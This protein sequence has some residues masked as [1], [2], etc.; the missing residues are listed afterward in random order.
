[1]SVEKLLKENDSINGAID[2]VLAENEK[3]D[4]RI[5]E[6]LENVSRETLESEVDNGK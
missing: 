5:N 4:Q 3:I 1:M 6:I 2:K